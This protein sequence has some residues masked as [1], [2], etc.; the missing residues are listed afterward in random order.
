MSQEKRDRL[1][2]LK[3]M[4][5]GVIRQRQ[6]AQWMEVIERWVKEL[7]R[8]NERVGDAEVGHGLRGRA[9]NRRVEE[10]LRQEPLG[11]LRQ[12]DW[13]NFGPTLASGQLAKR[14]MRVS[15]ETVRGWM[16]AEGLRESRRRKVK[17]VHECRPRRGP[18]GELVQWDTS[19]HDWLERRGEPVRR[20]ARMIEDA[21]SRSWG[22]F[23]LSDG[24]REN[25]SVLWE[26]QDRNGRM[27][28]V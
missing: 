17:D 8:R 7:L 11:L 9:S 25:I 3:Q 20:L 27:V 16:V 5:D 1:H 10:T 12:P 19:T 4:L 14:G 28:E 18:Y 13:H 24:T 22:R 15:R 26:Y 23:V 6:A 21:T 2:W